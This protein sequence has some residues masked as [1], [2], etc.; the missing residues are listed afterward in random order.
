MSTTKLPLGQAT[1]GVAKEATPSDAL[2][3]RIL[4]LEQRLAEMEARFRRANQESERTKPKTP[5]IPY[6]VLL[7]GTT[8]GI[9]YTLVRTPQGFRVGNTIYK[10]LSAAAEAVSGVRR[11]G[12]TFWHLPDG[13]TAKEVF[14]KK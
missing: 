10:S 2:E 7:V 8:R 1:M 14:G 12:W 4:V 11:S 6:D 13:R 9:Q 3:Q 5:N